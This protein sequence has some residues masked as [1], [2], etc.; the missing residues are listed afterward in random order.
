MSSFCGGMPSDNACASNSSRP[1]FSLEFTLSF[2]ISATDEEMDFAL[3]ED[4]ALLAKKLSHPVL[5]PK[6]NA[7][8]CVPRNKFHTYV[9]FINGKSS[10]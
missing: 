9:N 2:I 8:V 3:N 5:R 1:S 6:P 4:L 10:T 7:P